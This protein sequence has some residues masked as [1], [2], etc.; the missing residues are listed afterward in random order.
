MKKGVSMMVVVI[1]TVVMMI[2]ISSASVIGNESLKTA[3][4]EEYKSCIMR[5]QDDVNYYY[6]ENGSLPIQQEENG[7]I[8]VAIESL[9]P[10]LYQQIVANQDYLGNL[11][12][13]DI[14]KLE[15]STLSNTQDVFLIA[16]HSHHVYSMQGFLYHSEKYYTI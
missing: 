13:I 10:E 3:Q 12:L 15:D 11:Y 2:L 7:N 16:E 1:A 6:V 5:I 8:I 14:A 9:E 4:F